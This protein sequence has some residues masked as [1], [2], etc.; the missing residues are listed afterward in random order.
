MSQS[1]LLQQPDRLTEISFPNRHHIREPAH[2][3]DLEPDQQLVLSNG[4]LTVI[5]ESPTAHVSEREIT[6]LEI[7][8]PGKGGDQRLIPD[9]N[10]LEC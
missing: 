7:A 6:I 1:V 4:E 5:K 8:W 2:L 9:L 3:L 10:G